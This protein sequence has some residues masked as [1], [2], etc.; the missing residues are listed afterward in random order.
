MNE[1]YLLTQDER[2]LF[3]QTAANIQ[4]MPFEII[5]KDFWVVWILGRLFSLEKVSLLQR[6]VIHSL[7]ISTING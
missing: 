6:I 4:N 5:E 3:F 1:I 7:S 2:E